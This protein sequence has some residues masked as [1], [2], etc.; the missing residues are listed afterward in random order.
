MAMDAADRL[1]AIAAEMGL[2]LFH[3]FR[4]IK[5][6]RGS[7]KIWLCYKIQSCVFWGKNEEVENMFIM[8]FRN[9]F[10]VYV[11]PQ[12]LMPRLLMKWKSRKSSHPWCWKRLVKN[13]LKIIAKFIV[14][15]ILKIELLLLWRNCLSCEGCIYS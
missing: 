9:Y 4:K 11:C 12:L 8:F 3:I 15:L 10:D 14:K 2:N 1:S 13:N 5:I 7:R 6:I